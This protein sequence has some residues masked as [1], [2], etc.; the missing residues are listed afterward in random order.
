MS[1]FSEPYTCS[2]NKIKV[3]FHLSNYQQNMTEKNALG[4]NKSKIPEKAN[5]GSVKSE[6]D[7]LDIDQLE[8]AP[9]DLST[10]IDVVKMKLLK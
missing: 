4:V 7:K 5:F 3:E 1:Y 6:I 9:V 10:L 2:K 8:T